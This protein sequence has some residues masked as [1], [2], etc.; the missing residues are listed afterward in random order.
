MDVAMKPLLTDWL[1]KSTCFQDVFLL[2]FIIR[3]AFSF[4]PRTYIWHL[5]AA[6]GDQTSNIKEMFEIMKEMDN[7]KK[8]EMFEII[9][10][11][12][13][14]IVWVQWPEMTLFSAAFDNEL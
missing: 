7:K 14:N 4:F 13:N 9:K 5:T 6:Y 2:P 10:E 12:D 8:K 1:L 11:R 3:I